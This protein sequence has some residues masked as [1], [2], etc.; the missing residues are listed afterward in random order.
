MLNIPYT[1]TWYQNN[2]EVILHVFFNIFY[3]ISNMS[4]NYPKVGRWGEDRRISIPLITSLK[5][6]VQVHVVQTLDI[7]QTK[8]QSLCVIMYLRV[9]YSFPNNTPF[10]TCSQ[11]VLKLRAYFD[12]GSLLLS[13]LYQFAR[14]KQFVS[15]STP[16]I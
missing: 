12:T 1:C 14:N 7:K 15:N 4:Q 9:V 10:R 11:V 5:L 2:H 3:F 13:I 6:I 16:N 8:V